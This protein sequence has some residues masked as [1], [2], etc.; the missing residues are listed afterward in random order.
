MTSEKTPVS[1]DPDALLYTAEQVANHPLVKGSVGLVYAV[2]LASKEAGD[3]P[4]SGRITTARKFTAW[5]G[6][7][8]EFVASHWLRKKKEK[9]DATP[10]IA[11]PAAA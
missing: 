9:K 2:K 3:S 11:Q 7:H 6:A 10:S 1:S 4:F 8:P 5:I